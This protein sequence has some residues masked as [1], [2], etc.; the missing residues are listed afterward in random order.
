MTQY[1]HS[2]LAMKRLLDAV[3]ENHWA[4]WIATD[5][6]RW[7]ASG[8]TSHH[9]SA[10]GGM[11]SF[12]DVIICHAN[13]HSVTEVTE[14]WANTLLVWL[15]SVCYFL[16]K[17]PQHSFSPE[18][19]AAR[20]G[21]HDSSLA[22]FVGG[23]QAPA[24]MRGYAAEP[25]KLRGWR[26]LQCGQAE[27]TDRDIEYLMAQDLIPGMMFS[28]CVS[29]TL[30]KLV[31]KVLAADISGT[32]ETRKMLAVAVAASEIRLVPRDGW[33]WK[34]PHCGSDDTAVYRWVLC[35]GNECRFEPSADNL[36]LQE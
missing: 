19:L 29:Q 2:L 23:D 13:Q 9:L 21:L 16:A 5:I 10:Y 18:T 26:C 22:A 25:A 35:S 20:I 12:N 24:S 14:A 6:E 3:H 28:A 36:P 11:G 31:D 15:K 8:D 32:E 34:C 17:H 30:D 7:R 27:V 4:Q 33:N 1:E